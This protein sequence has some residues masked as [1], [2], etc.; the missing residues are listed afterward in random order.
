MSKIEYTWSDPP[1]YKIYE[2]PISF[3]QSTSGDISIVHMK[4]KS[5]DLISQREAILTGTRYVT[6]TF[7]TPRTIHCLNDRNYGTWMTDLPI[8]LNQMAT[9]IDEM[10]LHGN[11]LVGG[12]GLG[13]MPTWM[14]SLHFVDNI[15][16]VERSID[17]IKLCGKNVDFE[18]KHDDI[19]TSIRRIKKWNYDHVFLDTWQGTNEGTWWQHVFPLRRLIGNRFGKQKI[20]CWGEKIM[21]AQILQK[22]RHTDG[23][24]LGFKWEPHWHYKNQEPMSEEESRFFVENIGLPEWEKTYGDIWKQNT[25]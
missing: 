12:L 5:C 6:V 22:L 24:I 4:Q 15:V 21:L 16:V 18:I 9:A 8:E 23:K 11:V 3:P 2:S 25:R 1:I 13:V 10:N 20:Y 14:T 17:V 7:D 19:A